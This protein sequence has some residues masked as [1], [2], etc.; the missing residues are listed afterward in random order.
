VIRRLTIAVAVAAVAAG[1]G[2]APAVAGAAG[3]VSLRLNQTTTWP[4]REL[5]VSLPSRR[6][7]GSDQVRVLENGAPVNATKVVSA[8]AN[9]R[10]GVVLVID[11]SLTMTGAPIHQAMV[12]ARS[13]AKRRPQSTPLG[14]IF[15][16][17]APRVALR[18][19]TDARKIAATLALD[20]AP[21]R[22]TKI[23]DAAAAGVRA[24][25]EVGATSGAIVVL[26]DGA[27]AVNGSATTPAA[28]AAL[29]RSAS[30]RIF[31]VGLLSSSLNPVPLR[32][33][34]S[35][36]GGRYGEAA[37]PQDLPPLFAAIGD[38][39]SSEY[40]VTYRSTVQAGQSVG[41]L[42]QIAGFPGISH[43]AYRAPALSLGAL[44]PRSATRA[45]NGLD[46]LGVLLLGIGFFVVT[47]LVVYLIVHPKQRTLVSRVTDFA[48]GQD[49]PELTLRDV[50]RR[51]ARQPS[52]RWRRLSDAVELAGVGVSPAALV[53]LTLIGTVAAV[54]YLAVLAGRPALT[55]LALTVPLG[56]RSFVLSRLSARRRDF[57]EQLPDN[58]Q[59]LASS[60][61]AGYS[62]SAALASM[63]DDA[64]EPSRTELRRASTD[65]QLGVDVGDAL[66]SIGLRMQNTEI[67]YV[68]IVARM[69]REV[70]G[71]TAEVL[72][73]VIETIRSRQ[74]LRR[75]VRTLTAQGRMGGAIIAA[76][77]VVVSVAMAALHPGYFDPM[78][79]SPIGVILLIVGTLMLTCG[80][81][82][83]RKIVD[84]EP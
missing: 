12:A 1:A 71:N 51:P 15:F 72:E 57:E 25:R 26:S 33:M 11:A 28:L 53:L 32:T 66:A 56:V 49:A 59:V 54:L 34:A 77:P 67:D 64:P 27:E 7:L 82:I 18:P 36:T 19:T 46:P 44:R 73:Q 2:F 52:E 47:A 69:Q 9:R 80:W 5:L 70:G 21:T 83:I 40:L 17:A 4:A 61:R 10:R 29:A 24:L 41:V 60:L 35:G 48:G 68:G 79:Q 84:L 8:A 30:V 65:E 6:A 37:R 76:M 75:T 42:A 63:A 38:R 3:G 16:S 45:S 74:Q 23:F 20:P 39:L 81:L 22:G 78:L 50:R 43:L 31:S 55:I 58:L 14:V 13:F 62:F